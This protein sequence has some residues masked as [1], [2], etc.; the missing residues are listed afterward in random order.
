MKRYVLRLTNIR[1]YCLQIWPDL[2]SYSNEK[3]K[4]CS[5]F[6]FNSSQ[7]V[8][9]EKILEIKARMFKE[10]NKSIC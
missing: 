10:I 9:T 8:E 6:E 5:L 3:F 2:S 7:K 1:N 4:N